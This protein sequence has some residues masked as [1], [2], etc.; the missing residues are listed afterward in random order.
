MNQLFLHTHHLFFFWSPPNIEQ[1]S[2]GYPVDSHLLSILYTGRV[3]VCVLSHSVVSDSL[4]PHQALLSMEFSRQ[5]YWS[6]LPF[7][8]AG[9]LPNPGI[10]SISLAFP[11]LAGRFF[12]ISATWKLQKCDYIISN[13]PIHPSPSSFWCP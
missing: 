7:P 3:Y 1:S 12:T 2:R 11:A 6:V 4:Q 13:L 5:E 8:T 9:G 10:K